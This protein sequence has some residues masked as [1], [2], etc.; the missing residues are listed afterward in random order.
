MKFVPPWRDSHQNF[1]FFNFAAR[2]TRY[3]SCSLKGKNEI[4][5]F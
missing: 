1:S 5:I 3:E 2:G 4:L